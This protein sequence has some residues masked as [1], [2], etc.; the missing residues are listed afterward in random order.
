MDICGGDERAAWVYAAYEFAARLNGAGDTEFLGLSEFQIQEM[1]LVRRDLQT[2]REG[3]RTLVELGVLEEKVCHP[4]AHLCRIAWPVVKSRLLNGESPVRQSG[5]FP[6]AI[7]E[8]PVRQSGNFPTPYIGSNECLNGSITLPP[9][10]P[11]I[12]ADEYEAKIVS[13]LEHTVLEGRGVSGDDVS[14]MA[15]MLRTYPPRAQARALR[16]L[17]EALRVQR[18]RTWALVV[19][20]IDEDGR[21]FATTESQRRRPPQPHRRQEPPREELPA[22]SAE[23]EAWNAARNTE[24]NRMTRLMAEGKQAEAMAKHREILERFGPSFAERP[25]AKAVGAG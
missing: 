10:K 5:N 24:V 6:I 9:S 13:L 18:P 21:T 25:R 7:G 3:R 8:S 23:E 4:K 19:Q 16:K 14:T 20:I 1:L 17:A 11:V 12:P 15:A 2:I 22:I